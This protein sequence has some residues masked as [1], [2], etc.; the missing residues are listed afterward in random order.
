MAPLVAVAE[1]GSHGSDAVSGDD[2]ECVTVGTCDLFLMGT[3]ATDEPGL[4]VLLPAAAAADG[5]F[6]RVAG[7]VRRSRRACPELT[8]VVAEAVSASA[9]TVGLLFARACHRMK[10]ESRKIDSRY[11]IVVRKK[12]PKPSC[13]EEEK[14]AHA[15][16]R[17]RLLR[18]PPIRRA[19]TLT[20]N[21][22]GHVM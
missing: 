11:G 4:P 16:N 1:P 19:T 20:L 18:R 6:R 9:F 3:V 7:R 21:I 13:M 22:Y 5:A 10:C 8:A 17:A 2:V 14:K 12:H 15:D